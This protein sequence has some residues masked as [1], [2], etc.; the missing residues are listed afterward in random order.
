M[1]WRRT[2]SITAALAI[3]GSV[4]RYVHDEGLARHFIFTGLFLVCY[5]IIDLGVGRA[6][7]RDA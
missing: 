2:L 4:N 6:V 5:Y 3:W 1:R 7:R